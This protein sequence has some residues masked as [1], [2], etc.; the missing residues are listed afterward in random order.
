MADNVG[1]PDFATPSVASARPDVVVGSDFATASVARAWAKVVEGPDFG[2]ASVSEGEDVVGEPEPE[3]AT[4]VVAEGPDLATVLFA[5]RE[6]FLILRRA[7]LRVIRK[8]IITIAPASDHQHRV[9]TIRLKLLPL[10]LLL[11]L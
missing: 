7:H 4:A 2:T 5:E 9:S 1:G 8:K 11:L 6:T 3:V 10:L